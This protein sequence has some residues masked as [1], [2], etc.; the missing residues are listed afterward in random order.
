MVAAEV[1]VG[2][3][4][5]VSVTLC[6]IESMMV[7]VILRMGAV[8]KD[9]EVTVRFGGITV[10][11]THMVEVDKADNLTLLDRVGEVFITGLAEDDDDFTVDMADV[12]EILV[13]E[14][15]FLETVEDT[16]STLLKTHLQACLT[17]GVFHFGIGESVLGLFTTISKL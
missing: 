14:D 11:V 17:A 1:T 15:D 6:Q 16:A 3:D 8:D 10:L 5:A 7:D 4:V 12:G 13:L 9:V 2:V